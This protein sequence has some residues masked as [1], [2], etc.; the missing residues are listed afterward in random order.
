M[1]E[2]FGYKIHKMK[3]YLFVINPASGGRDKNELL[4]AI[5]AHFNGNGS[6][7]E[8]FNTTGEN[9]SERL[10]ERIKQ[11]RPDVVVISGGDGT[12]NEMTNV[13]LEYGIPTGIIPMGSANGLAT[14]LGITDE[15]AIDTIQNGLARKLDVISVNDQIMVHMADMGL[16]ATLVK[17]YEEEGRRGFL[18]YA[19]SALKELPA[20]DESFQVEIE[21]DGQKIS[22]TTK[23]LVIANARMYGTG[24]EVNPRANIGDRKVELCIMRDLLPDL[25]PAELFERGKSERSLFEIHPVRS[26]QITTNI[27][28][29]WQT[30]GQ[31]QGTTDTLSVRVLQNQLNVLCP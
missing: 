4:S 21:F 5:G 14:E 20:L 22:A 10:D 24:Y 9:D 16:N 11:A 6:K 15:N 1:H 25:I 26:A 29:N 27:P 28:V 19:I 31:Y 30:D 23:F 2:L 12:I 17:R 18:G 3:T 8:I 7:S 13:L